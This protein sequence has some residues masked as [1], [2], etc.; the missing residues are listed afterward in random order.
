MHFY[1]TQLGFAQYLTE[2]TLRVAE[3]ESDQQ[4]LMH[5]MPGKIRICVGTMCLTT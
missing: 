4:V 1:L 2:N 5:T 3:D